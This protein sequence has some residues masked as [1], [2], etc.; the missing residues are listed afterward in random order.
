M[1]ATPQTHVHESGASRLGCL[2]I[3]GY[4]GSPFE[5][6]GLAA[7]LDGEGFSTGLVT[8][9]GHGE[10]YKDF[11]KYGFFDWLAHAEKEYAA[12]AERHSRVALIGFSL[13]GTLALNL[14][15]RFPVAGIVTISTP[16]FTLGIFPWPL[17]NLKFYAATG[18]AL[19]L[20]LLNLQQDR[21][22]RNGE[23]SRDIAPWQ[24]FRGPLHW[25]HL[26]TLRKGCATTRALMS[27]ITAPL[28][29]IQ[30]AR[31]GLVNPNNL[32]EI[33]RRISSVDTS[34]IL[35]RMRENVSRHHM[36]PT[37]RETA[38][39]AAAAVVRFC[40]EKT[41]DSAPRQGV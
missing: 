9:P 36:V 21:V 39:Q 17:D 1:P 29:A 38:Q 19:V 11:G 8:L 27:S 6:E 37:H 15:A 24:G 18:K 20:R 13:G 10:G 28:L 35:T 30:D 5:V 16:L 34:V 32:W 23:T 12:F 4:G 14:A 31:D 25:R 7:A 33:A 40:R 41:L 26:L 2:L 22:S 3:H